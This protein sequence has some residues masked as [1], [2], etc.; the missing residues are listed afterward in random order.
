[1]ARVEVPPVPYVEV[2]RRTAVD[3]PYEA[4]LNEYVATNR[5]VVVEGAGSKW[6]AISKWTPEFF[7]AQFGSKLVDVS[8]SERMPFADFIDAV[9]ASTDEKPGPYMFRLFIC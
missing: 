1:M 4:F 8:R 9:L 3:L 5:P 7:K 6:P 2:E